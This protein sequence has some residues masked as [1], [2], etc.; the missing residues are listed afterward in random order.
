MAKW[1]TENSS[2]THHW[3]IHPVPDICWQ[4]HFPLGQPLHKFHEQKAHAKPVCRLWGAILCTGLSERLPSEKGLNNYTVGLDLTNT[5]HTSGKKGPR[6][7]A[8]LAGSQGLAIPTLSWAWLQTPQWPR[9][10]R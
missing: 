7:V 8:A 6:V 9:V 4:N 1:L 2:L 3:W 5:L 10:G